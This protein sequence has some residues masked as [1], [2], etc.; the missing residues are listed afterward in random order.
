M[1]VGQWPGTGADDERERGEA[2]GVGQDPTSRG[3]VCPRANSIQ[4]FLLY[5]PKSIV[6]VARIKRKVSLN[7][8]DIL[9]AAGQ[10]LW[11]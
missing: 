4:L 10:S 5:A 2:E 7:T 9:G 8:F 1:F 6:V 11:K 3:G